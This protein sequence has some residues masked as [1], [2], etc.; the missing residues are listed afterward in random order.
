MVYEV[1]LAR[2]LGEG[3]RQERVGIGHQ[4][5]V[6]KDDANTVGVVAAPIECSFSRVGF[7]C[8][9]I[10]PNS[11]EHLLTSSRAVPKAVLRWIRAKA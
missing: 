8:K 9:T 1:L 11:E 6:I 5:V 7:C 3:G 4:A 10:I 2:V